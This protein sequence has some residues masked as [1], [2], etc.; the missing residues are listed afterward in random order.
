MRASTSHSEIENAAAWERATPSID[1]SNISVPILGAIQQN[2]I[3]AKYY[4]TLVV[5]CVLT[6]AKLSFPHLAVSSSSA[7]EAT[8]STS[9]LWSSKVEEG[10]KAE[11][12]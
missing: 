2:L 6:V 4:L 7:T 12:L 1:T 11:G 8:V 10:R 3:R 5:L 9:L